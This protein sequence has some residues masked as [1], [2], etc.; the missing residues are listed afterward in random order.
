MRH[1]TLSLEITCTVHNWESN[2]YTCRKLYS[3][4]KTLFSFQTRRCLTWR[5]TPA[6]TLTTPSQGPA[7]ASGPWPRVDWATRRQTQ[8]GEV[9]ILLTTC[10]SASCSV[11]TSC[12]AAVR[13]CM[14]LDGDNNNLQHLF[15][16]FYAEITSWIYNKMLQHKTQKKHGRQYLKCILNDM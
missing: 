16:P 14:I 8:T 10:V 3:K 2:K 12:S 4:L 13:C 15:V 11:Q 6:W 5:W 1:G 7:P 9:E